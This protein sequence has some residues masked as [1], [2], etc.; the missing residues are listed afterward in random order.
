MNEIEPLRS[1]EP[2]ISLFIQNSSPKLKLS[3]G[4]LDI[5]FERS[6][7]F[8]AVLASTRK[9]CS[10]IAAILSELKAERDINPCLG[11]T[12]RLV[13]GLESLIE[14]GESRPMILAHQQSNTT[15]R[16]ENAQKQILHWLHIGCTLAERKLHIAT[17]QR[18]GQR[19]ISTLWTLDIDRLVSP[20]RGH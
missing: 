18:A 12:A 13:V 11:R 6:M 8:I 16:P 5:I 3:F 17:L 2:W 7:Y 9:C 14:V 20:S 1:L 10:I 15:R 19:N 4:W